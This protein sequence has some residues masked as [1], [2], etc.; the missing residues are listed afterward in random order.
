ML[1]FSGNLVDVQT[2]DYNSL[3]FESERYDS[4][5][6]KNVTYAEM[7]GVA[8]ECLEFMPNYRK[9]I[10]QSIF[11]GVSALKTKKGG[12]FLLCNTDVLKVAKDAWLYFFKQCDFFGDGR[13]Y[14]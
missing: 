8:K 5:L 3:I 13:Y 2:G 12:I 7:V 4:R 1:I 9:Y 14:N 11:V 6:K 10:G